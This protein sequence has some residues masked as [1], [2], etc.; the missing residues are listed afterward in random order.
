MPIPPFQ[1]PTS[2]L[3]KIPKFVVPNGYEPVANAFDKGFF[4]FR[5]VVE[6]MYLQNEWKVRQTWE[7]TP[8]LDFS[9]FLDQPENSAIHY[10]V[11]Y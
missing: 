8:D 3:P 11:K 2:E 7:I 10:C 1:D 6:F 4:G 9:T 5:Q